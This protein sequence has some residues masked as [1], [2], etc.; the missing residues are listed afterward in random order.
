MKQPKRPPKQ[1][2]LDEEIE[3]EIKKIADVTGLSEVE[4]IRQMVK[5]GVVALKEIGYT[6]PTPLRVKVIPS[7]E[8]KQAS[9]A[10][11]SNLRYQPSQSQFNEV[12]E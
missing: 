8:P 3:A 10:I 1:V 11:S 6:C 2:R 4:I 7:E 9:Q 12:H 5:A